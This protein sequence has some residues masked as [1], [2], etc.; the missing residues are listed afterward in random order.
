MNTSFS[1]FKTN[2]RKYNYQQ[3]HFILFLFL[4]IFYQLCY[5]SCFIFSSLFLF[6]QYPHSLQHLPHLRSCP[7]VVHIIS[8][9]SPFPI[10]FLTSPCLFSTYQLCFL[11]P[12]LF[13]PFFLS[14]SPLITLHVISISVVL[15]LFQLFAQFVFVFLG[16]VVDSCEFVV[17][18]LFIVL[19]FFF[20]DKPLKHFI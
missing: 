19:I 1:G 5:Y 6:T 16:S 9:T 13:P 14:T 8:L 4:S 18:L 20:L 15:F 2:V 17:I 11:F 3:L 7:W 12:V 10:L